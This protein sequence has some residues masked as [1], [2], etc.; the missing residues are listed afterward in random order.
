MILEWLVSKVALMNS[1]KLGNGQMA[2]EVTVIF[3]TSPG[4]SLRLLFPA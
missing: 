2:S 1:Q 4:A 3:D